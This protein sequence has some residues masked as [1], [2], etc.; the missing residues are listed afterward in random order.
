LVYKRVQK[1]RALGAQS[2]PA[3]APMAPA[4]GDD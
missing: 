2:A 3:G 1:Q 4:H